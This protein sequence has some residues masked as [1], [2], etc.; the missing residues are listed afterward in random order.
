[1]PDVEALKRLKSSLSSISIALTKT[2]ARERELM[3]RREQTWF[4]AEA[5]GLANRAA[6]AKYSGVDPMLVSRSLNKE[7]TDGD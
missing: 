4:D 7:K 2:R 5:Q 1:M 6:L 3:Q